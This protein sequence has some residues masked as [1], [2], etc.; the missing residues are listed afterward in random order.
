MI[1]SYTLLQLVARLFDFY[2]MLVLIYCIM[3]WLPMR[4]GGLV[5][6]FAAVLDRIVGPYL[7]LFRRFIPPLGGIDFSPVLA[8]IALNLIERLVLNILW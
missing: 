7:N 1:T 3:T 2:S 4:P 5:E 8:I 6:D